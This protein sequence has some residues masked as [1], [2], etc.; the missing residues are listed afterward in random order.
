MRR[1]VVGL[2][3]SLVL[4]L[5]VVA[6][7]QAQDQLPVVRAVLFFNP[8]C[9]RCEFVIHEVL[10]PLYETHGPQLQIIGVNTMEPEGWEL[11][12]AAVKRFAIPEER[13]GV[14]TLIVGETVLVGSDEIPER[15]PALI[16]EGLA[17]GGVAWPDIPGLREVLSSPGLTA[18]SNSGPVFPESKP[19]S[20]RERFARDRV[21]NT[22]AVIVLLGMVAAL[23]YV[24]LDSRHVLRERRRESKPGRLFPTW[25]VP[26]LALVGLGVASYLTYV[27]I[28][29]V[30]AVCGPVGDCNTVQ[31]SP[32]ARLFG[33]LPVGVLGV[34][35]YLAILDAWAWQRI[36]RD[37]RRKAVAALLL[38]GMAAIGTLFS[39][40][41]TFLE[42]FV[43]GATCAWCLSS[44]VIMTA[45]LL[46]TARPGV[47]AARMLLVHEVP[48]SHP[49]HLR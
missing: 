6:P 11:Y 19:L 20:L 12:Q 3:L 21:G 48:E 39:I 35:G 44:A 24:V 8:G 47:Q 22:L 2:L 49:A 30:K 46:L 37:E 15:F 36:E 31:H 26:A 9:P 10:P 7:I 17:A 41:L 1:I 16:E 5:P 29:E 27:E 45:L 33:V 38:F 43:I 32:Y 14:P 23:G 25:L 40:Y 28:F 42:P 34:V 18:S 4:V 13:Q